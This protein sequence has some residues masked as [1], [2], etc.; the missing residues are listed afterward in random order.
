MSPTSPSRPERDSPLIRVNAHVAHEIASS[1][2]GLVASWV[3][4][5]ERAASRRAVFVYELK[6]VHGE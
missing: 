2:E 5:G 4:A 3:L 1:G 6:D